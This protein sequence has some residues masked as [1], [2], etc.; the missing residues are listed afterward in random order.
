M[1]MMKLNSVQIVGRVFTYLTQRIQNSVLG[2][3]LRFSTLPR[4]I[5]WS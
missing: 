1:G 3:K 5:R 2:A 4:E